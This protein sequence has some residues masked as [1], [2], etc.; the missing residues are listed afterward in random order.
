MIETKMTVMIKKEMKEVIDNKEL[1]D[2][3]GRNDRG[4]NDRG[5]DDK[6]HRGRDDRE[7]ADKE[8]MTER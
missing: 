6:D 5:R 1:I 4:R 2:D 8:V 3:R 7:G